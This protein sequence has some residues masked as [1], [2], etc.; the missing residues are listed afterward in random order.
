M[1]RTTIRTLSSTM[2]NPKYEPQLFLCNSDP[3]CTFEINF[4]TL[5]F[6]SIL[7]IFSD[8]SL[9]FDLRRFLHLRPYQT[10]MLRPPSTRN[11]WR[12]SNESADV[13]TGSLKTEKILLRDHLSGLVTFTPL[14]IR[15]SY[16]MRLLYH[17]QQLF[18]DIERIHCV[19]LKVYS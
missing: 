13:E 15:A 4:F 7:L 3:H 2:Q 9:A 1:V 5:S 12:G 19:S 10:K 8:M 14:Q 18:I 11:T 6:R 16:L 17:Y